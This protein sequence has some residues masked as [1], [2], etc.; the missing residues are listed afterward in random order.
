VI[1]ASSSSATTLPAQTDYYNTSAGRPLRIEDA[2]P[3]EYHAMELDLAPLRIERLGGRT[4]H[5]SIHPE[6]TI[7][8]FPRTQ[9]QIG[10]PFSYID[11][12]GTA[13]QG[14]AGLDV[15]ALYSFNA[16]TAIPALALAADVSLPVGSLGGERTYGT[17]KAILTRT[18][19]AI[20]FHANFQM[21][22]GPSSPSADDALGKTVVDNRETSRW[23]GGVALDKTFPLRSLLISAEAFAEQPLRSEETIAWSAGGGLR[24]QLSPRWA[25]DA[26]AGRRFTGDDRTWY[27]TL[28]SAYAFGLR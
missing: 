13:S 17:V 23:M 26:G 20:R 7:G 22:A 28:G 3:V 12:A 5:W 24:Y 8:I 9:L 19:P 1:L 25:M 2:A 21:T 11:V 18:F 6:T 15:A 27:V 16:E 10:V 14:V 4:R